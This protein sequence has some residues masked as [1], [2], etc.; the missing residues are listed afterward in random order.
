MKPGEPGYR[1]PETE[2]EFLAEVE[3]LPA[4]LVLESVSR[5]RA[6]K[7]PL[8]RTATAAELAEDRR[9]ALAAA[10]AFGPVLATLADYR[11]MLVRTQTMP[12]VS[13]R[14]LVYGKESDH[15]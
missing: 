2:A 13:S 3:A 8:E 15:D 11:R 6:S 7:R 14:E 12:E 5:R 10:E 9:R 4:P 1:G